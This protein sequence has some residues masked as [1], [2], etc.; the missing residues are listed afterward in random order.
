MPPINTDPSTIGYW[1]RIHGLS[2]DQIVEEGGPIADAVAAGSREDFDEG[3]NL[4]DL[5]LQGEK[6]KALALSL[7]EAHSP[8]DEAARVDRRKRSRVRDAMRGF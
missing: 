8:D 7:A 2:Y 6:M 4:A 1:A 5:E 3:W